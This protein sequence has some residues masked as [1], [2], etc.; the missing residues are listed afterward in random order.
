M[1][2]AADGGLDLARGT[3]LPAGVLLFPPTD[4]DRLYRVL[5][6][7]FC[8]K[9]NAVER[10][11]RQGVPFLAW[12]RAGAI[13]LTQG[14]TIDYDFI[15]KAITDDGKK[16]DIRG[17]AAD[18]WNLEF[19]RQ[20]LAVEG[21]EMVEFVQGFRSYTDPTKE[22]LENLLPGCKIAHG[23][24]VVFRWMASNLMVIED[25]AGNKK[26]DK[27]KSA[28]AIDGFSALIMALGRYMV[29]KDDTGSVY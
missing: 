10:D 6:R 9:D 11:R 16:F 13:T 22:L 1:G 15:K 24:H 14:N 4:D 19:L 25:P 29:S 27:K 20:R 5:P 12:A 26:P 18:S 23:G 8:P 7:C 2:A 17:I 21:V 28:D 3:D